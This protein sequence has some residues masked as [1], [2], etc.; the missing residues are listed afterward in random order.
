MQDFGIGSWIRRHA[1]INPSKTALIYNDDVRSYTEFHSRI[2]KFANGLRSVGARR[3]DRIGYFGANHPAFFETLFAS[4]T[5]GAMFVQV[6]FRFTPRDLIHVLNDSGCRILVYDPAASH[7]IDEVRKDVNVQTYIAADEVSGSADTISSLCANQP[8]AP[9]EVAVGLDELCLISYTSG[10]TGRPKG[11]MLS[12][13]NLTWNVFNFLSCADY[14]SDDIVL[15]AAPLYR[16]GGLGVSV[17]PGLYKGAT[18]VITQE[19]DPIGLLR[20]IEHRRITVLFGN[21]DL[22]RAL[23]ASSEIY[24]ADLSS[25]R[26]CICGGDTVPESLIRAWLARGVVFQQGYG[27]TEAAPLVLLLNKDEMLTKIGSS[28]KPPMFTE[29]RVVNPELSDVRPREIGEILVRGPNVMMGYWNL[30][31]VTAKKFTPDGWLRTG[32]AARI[33][34]DGHIYITGRVEDAINLGDRIVYPS[35]IEKTIG[36]YSGVSDCAVSG[37]KDDSGIVLTAFVVRYPELTVTAEELLSRMHEDL[38]SDNVPVRIK[39]VESIPRNP[40]GKIVRHLL[41][42]MARNESAAGQHTKQS[43]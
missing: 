27:L 20:L 16:M 39:F 31:E 12:H 11:V 14:L 42:G 6:H 19:S 7:I 30:P 2:L 17:L 5:I 3:G 28:G 22:F 15:A 26:F 8:A 23:L 18:V 29:V 1:E 21:P 32:D 9:L 34:D 37:I 41:A 40:N 13:G 36:S 33:D 25:V 24:N 38:P 35:E 10:T 4:A 43:A